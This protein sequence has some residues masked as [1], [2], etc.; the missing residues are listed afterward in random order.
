MSK[1]SSNIFT[2]LEFEYNIERSYNLDTEKTQVLSCDDKEECFSYDVKRKTKKAKTK[3]KNTKASIKEKETDTEVSKEISFNVGANT[4]ELGI[5]TSTLDLKL[6]PKTTGLGVIDISDINTS[7]KFVNTV[8]SKEKQKIQKEKQRIA[9]ADKEFPYIRRDLLTNAEFVF[10]RFMKDNLCQSNKIE[11]FPKVRLAD[12]ADVDS[13]LTTDNKYLWKIT[14]K[15][16]DFVICRADTLKIICVVELDDYMHDRPEV[17]E[18]D[19]FIMQVLYEVGIRTVRVRNRV[20]KLNLNDIALIDDYINTELAPKCPY[21][22][23]QMV[24]KKCMQGPNRGHR[25][26]GCT[27][28]VDNCRVTINID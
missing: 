18:K 14:N 26:Y 9:Q 25:F 15:H 27:N 7:N 13:K 24:P 3:K 5:D 22:G 1:D 8:Q 11:I 21:C 16:V 19:M 6:K 23:S 12:L 17:Q 10:Y 2:T 4:S 20:A 28:Y